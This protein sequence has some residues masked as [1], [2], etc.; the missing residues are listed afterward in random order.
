MIYNCASWVPQ[1]SQTIVYSDTISTEECEYKL[2]IFKVV[3]LVLD[4]LD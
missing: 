4:A 1:S 3:L 2:S